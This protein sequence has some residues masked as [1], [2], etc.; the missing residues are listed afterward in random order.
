MDERVLQTQ[1]W[2]NNTYGNIDSFPTVSE[3]G[4]TG[5]ATFKA[6]VY[7]LQIE[8]GISNPDGIFGND[9]LGRCP[10]LTPSSNPE[11]AIPDNLVYILQGSLCCKGISPGGFTG[12]F[13]PQTANAV[14][15][16]QNLA[17]IDADSVVKPYILQGIMNTDSYSFIATSD[18]F[19]TYKHNVQMGLNQYYGEK[20]GLIAPNGIWERKSQTNL[21]KAAQIE[22]NAT[23][24][25]KWGD[26]TL[27][28][29]P[30]LSQ[31]TSGYKNS[32]R[33]LQWALT[34][35]GFYPGVADGIWGTATFNA[36]YNFQ[37]FLCLGADGICGRR[38][39]AS[40]MSSKGDIS[41]PANALDTS[42][43][44]E[45]E[46]AT[47]LYQNGYR[48]IGRYLTNTPGGKLDKVLYLYELTLLR[49]AGLNIF[50]IY[51]TTGGSSSYFT[52]YQGLVDGYRAVKAA[53][54]FGFPENATIYFAIDYDVLLKDIESCIMPYFRSVKKIVTSYFNVGVY[55][56]RL[57]CT[58]LYEADLTSTSFVS[59][60]S[61]GFTCNIG[62]KMPANWAYDQFCEVPDNTSEYSSMGYDKIIASSRKT[63]TTPSEF[64][65]Y[66]TID[67]PDA[68]FNFD[69]I[70]KLYECATDYLKNTVNENNLIFES[71]KLV[72]RYLRQHG[73]YGNDAWN[74]I[75]EEID[76]NFNEHIVKVQNKESIDLSSNTIYL[77]D[78]F[79]REN[80][81][82][83]H[84]AATLG[85]YLHDIVWDTPI[86][87]QVDAF[88]GWA[89]DLVQIG[90]VLSETVKLGGN[91]YLS[92]DNLYRFIGFLDTELVNFQF[93][94]ENSDNIESTT[95]SGFEYADLIQDVDAFNIFKAYSFHTVPLYEILENYYVRYK[96]YK[97]RF[98][99][100]EFNLK[101]EFNRNS[102]EEIAQLFTKPEDLTLIALNGVFGLM[103]GE[104]DHNKY[105]PLL[106]QAFASKI[107]YYIQME[108]NVQVI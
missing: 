6:L 49:E 46:T 66:D 20:I 7:A 89:G 21:I 57:I 93:L 31:N 27:S 45:A 11:E 32:K 62:Q 4:I 56:P 5:H 37:D 3:D 64:R 90:S 63:A 43:Q 12:I 24:D 75:A 83:S 76:T 54:D 33:I 101:N 105:G 18:I 69:K 104:Y 107:E 96:S 39:W 13:G 51:Q 99:L 22:W 65:D 74:F 2:L 10:T 26:D 34:I 73:P 80:L 28:K 81:E 98:T 97:N 108:T 85:A 88:A 58:K 82:I 17:G 35:N 86:N 29:A 25:G 9:T 78:G 102:I 36:L 50:P 42:K 38:T 19:D 91:D 15:T 53:K 23:V 92:L 61:S 52:A 103:F 48:D 94:K 40:L 47:L 55:G 87:K 106:A 70:K 84:F 41:R 60:M 59:D 72:L 8:I 77:H 100:F 30:V 16:F 79:S 95:N 71:N 67:Y 1:T 14:S 68:E 44:V